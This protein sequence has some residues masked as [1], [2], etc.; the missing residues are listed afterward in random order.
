LSIRWWR[1]D[2][3]YF[4]AIG[5][6]PPDRLWFA[7]AELIF[8][9][10]CTG[11]YAALWQRW[12]NWR[13]AHRALAVAA[14]SNL[15]LHFPAH[16]AIISVLS[17]RT[18]RLGEPIGR[19]GYRQML[20]DPEVIS[21][22]THVWLAAFAVSGAL[23]MA[24]GSRARRFAPGEPSPVRLIQRGACLAL[25]PTLLQVPTGFWVALEMPDT[26]RARLVGGDLLATGLF[27]AAV[28][29]T[30]S[31]MHSLASIALGEHDRRR[32]RNSI[33]VLMLIM[34]LMVG[35][36]GR[37]SSRSLSQ[38]PQAKDRPAQPA[39]IN[40]PLHLASGPA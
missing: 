27:A 17:T 33:L 13:L 38:R 10:V 12:R 37:V 14:A 25:I 2:P 28:L 11:C 1:D 36:R 22:V 3:N 19:A 39:A 4:R 20:I 40:S 32:I 23:L 5:D 16:F 26:L 7:L 24:L 18:A 9:L 21:R 31:L 34:L 15:M 6:I 29:F 30:L 8:F 35:A